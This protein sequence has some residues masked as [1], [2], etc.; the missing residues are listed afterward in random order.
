MSTPPVKFEPTISAGERL[1]TSAINRAATGTGYIIHAVVN[2]MTLTAGD[3]KNSLLQSVYCVTERTADSIVFLR[4]ET[5]QT[6]RKTLE[7]CNSQNGCCFYC[8]VTICLGRFDLNCLKH[9]SHH[10]SAHRHGKL[11]VSL[12]FNQMHQ[13]LNVPCL[14]RDC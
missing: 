13:L 5:E 14:Y 9:C 6:S 11:F 12:V 4:S 8:S 7:L 2:S 1:Q 10:G 3:V